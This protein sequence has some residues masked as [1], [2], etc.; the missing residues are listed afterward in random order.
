MLFRVTLAVCLL[1]LGMTAGLIS[2]SSGQDQQT[3]PI[4]F[5]EHL[6]S[7]D[8]T[9]AFGV[10]AGDLDGD[11]DLDLTS[12]DALPH[13]DL[14]WFEN[15]GTG[16]FTRRFI[17]E[18]DPERLERHVLADI[19]SDGHL[20]V[21]I[22]ENLRGDLKWFRN[23]GSPRDGKLWERHY[24]TKGGW[25]SAYDVTVADFDGDKDLDVAASG[26]IGNAIAWF[27][28]DGTPRDG[29]WNKHLIDDATRD[30]RL[31]ETR[32]IR[33]GDL[34]G[35]GDPDLLATALVGGLVVWYE[36][37]GRN[38]EARWKK[39]L[40]DDQSPRPVHGHPIDVDGD[41][42][43]DIVMALGFGPGNAPDAVHQVVW[44]EN[45]GKPASGPWK[46]HVIAE[47]LSMAFE[48]FAGDV[49]GDSDLDVVATCWGSPGQVLWLEN[50]GNPKEKWR[51]HI[52]KSPWPRAN[53]VI[54]ADVNGDKRLDI[55]A[56]AERGSNELRWWE[57]KSPKRP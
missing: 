8:Y 23:S 6:I 37:T 42:D 10:Q 46:K 43:L 32:T 41:K 56:C 15:D 26:W 12:A 7:S 14:Y 52:L 40:I 9:Y 5:A 25:P 36:N 3:A 33:A 29:E 28:N 2:F 22:V 1:G 16:K 57:N 24:I 51:T 19:D 45:D 21:V 54:L 38:D 13:N 44:Y 49:D 50:T 31:K 55:V 53:Q 47:P 4:P 11:G 30:P 34:D 39:H 27:E 35:D 17:Q 18:D 20:D 48:A